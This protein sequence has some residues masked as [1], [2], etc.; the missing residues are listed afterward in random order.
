MSLLTNDVSILRSVGTG[1]MNGWNQPDLSQVGHDI[2]HQL[3][4]RPRENKQSW[5]RRLGSVEIKSDHLYSPKEVAV[6]LSVS[7]DT[8]ARI[9]SRMKRSANLAKPHAKKRL[10]RVRGSDLRDYIQGKLV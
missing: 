9:M 8:A 1:K 6:V 5:K 3:T 2:Y 7:Y 4:G 10:L